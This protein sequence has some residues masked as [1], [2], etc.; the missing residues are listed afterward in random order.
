MLDF[1]SHIAQDIF[2]SGAC[3][4]DCLSWIKCDAVVHLSTVVET[5]AVCSL[6]THHLGLGPVRHWDIETSFRAMIYECLLGYIGFTACSSAFRQESP[7][8]RVN[9]H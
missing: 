7:L 2:G 5:T 3:L 9:P 8:C 6:Y 4:L 1:V